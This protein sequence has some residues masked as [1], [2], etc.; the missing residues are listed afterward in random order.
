VISKDEVEAKGAEFGLHAANIERDYVFGWL[1]AGIYNA[2][3]L[4]E[5]L[6]LKG[7]AHDRAGHNE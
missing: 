1:L 6:V 5:V 4:R 3:P 7:V 2:S